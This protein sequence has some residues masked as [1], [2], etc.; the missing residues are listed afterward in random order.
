MSSDAPYQGV[1]FQPL[2]P[3]V[4]FGTLHLASVGELDSLD[5]GPRD[6]V[7]TDGIPN[8]IPLIAGLIT[9][10]FQTPL[11]HVNVL[12]RGRGTPNMALREARKDPRI[13]PF[14]G[15]LVRYEV[16]GADFQITLADPD[17]AVAFWE[18]RKPSGDPISPRVDVSRRG[19][20]PLDHISLADVPLVGG[21]AA[22]LAELAQVE[23]CAGDVSVPEHAFAIPVVHSL[24]HF[25]DSG[26]KALLAELRRD[27]RFLA[28][29]D[30]RAA[31]LLRVQDAILSH[32]LDP[33]LHDEIE[34]AVAERWPNRQLRFR[35]SSNVEDLA[36]FNGAGL[37]LSE[38]VDAD[39]AST[40][41]DDAIRS[42]WASLWNDRGFAEREYYGVDQTQV[43][44][45][46]L[47]HPGFPSE[48]ANGVA[49]TRSV[50]DPTRDDLVTV[51]A[52]VG[53]ALVTNPAPGIISDEFDMSTLDASRAFYNHSSFSPKEPVLSADESEFLVCNSRAIH[54]HF[55]PLLD[56]DDENPWFAMDI[57]FKLVGPGRSLVIKQARSYSFGQTA[58]EG[59][60]AF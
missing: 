34:A 30:A 53:E 19:I 43:A 32:P 4:A 57:E 37:Y 29:P 38:G 15:K 28:D 20:V 54:D 3:G 2:V 27:A 56:P 40:R 48:R 17:E 22:Q 23:F 13:A 25:E 58:P 59:W 33:A 41:I 1:T 6:I 47:V 36:G 24:E 5:L 46:I 50:I 16:F 45:A 55:K 51:N 42:V 35:S 52:Q 18:S 26:A 8:E 39:A 14:I 60:C 31:G 44:M 9:E 7:L 49:I 10:T 12:S 21:K 11:A